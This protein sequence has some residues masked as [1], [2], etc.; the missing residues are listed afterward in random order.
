MELQSLAWRTDLALLGYSGSEVVDRGDH[1]VVRTPDNPSY[2][3]GNFLLL[4]DVASTRDLPDL[5]ARFAAEYPSAQH[6]SIGVDGTAGSVAE[7]A[8]LRDAGFETEGSAVMTATAVHAPPRPN[9]EATIRPLTSDEDWQEQV[10]LGR[11]GEEDR[12]LPFETAKVAAARRLVEQGRG[13]W[14]GA[15]LDGELVSSLGIFVASE[16]LARF[17]DVKTHPDFRGRGLCGTLV[18]A[19]GRYAFDEMGVHTLVMVAD[20]D[21]LAIRVYRSVGFEE[22]ETQLTALRKPQAAVPTPPSA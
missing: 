19:A 1:L 9:T 14:F 17:Q 13:Q 3:W 4:P 12:T 11:A 2:Y 10:P 21:Y 8:T 15:F 6:V 22:T 20:P 16:G 18:H 5:L 7:L